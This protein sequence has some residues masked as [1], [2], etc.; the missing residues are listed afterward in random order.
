MK[1]GSSHF[2]GEPQDSLERVDL[3]ETYESYWIPWE[4]H[5]PNDTNASPRLISNKKRQGW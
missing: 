5:L 4:N 3:L 1:M 2:L